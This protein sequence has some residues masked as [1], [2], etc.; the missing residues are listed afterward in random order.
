MQCV[1]AAWKRLKS[2]KQ[3]QLKATRSHSRHNELLHTPRELM[4]FAGVL[5]EA[6]ARDR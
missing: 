4:V 1:C 5:R 3:Q 6:A 2:S